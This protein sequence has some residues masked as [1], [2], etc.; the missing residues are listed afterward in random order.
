M[1]DTPDNLRF[2]GDHLWADPAGGSVLRV[3][4]TDYAQ[5]SLGDV[6]AVTPPEVGTTV[7]AGE[8]CGDI[9][10]TKSLSDLIAPLTGTVEER[11]DQLLESPEVVNSDPYGEGWIFAA[12]VDPATVAEQ[13]NRLM[14][15]AGYR[16]LT[17]G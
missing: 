6:I 12:R 4:I 15:G 7:T 16:D 3:G 2:N 17:G 11:N 10:S 14:D 9:E 8:P 1:T 5:Q 13:L